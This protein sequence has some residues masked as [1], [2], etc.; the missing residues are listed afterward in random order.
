MRPLLP[1]LSAS[2]LYYTTLLGLARSPAYLS[3]APLL[4]L[5]WP[6]RYLSTVIPAYLYPQLCFLTPF[7]LH[8]LASYCILLRL[9]SNFPFQIPPHV[10][11]PPPTT[12]HFR[13]KYVHTG[14]LFLVPPHPHPASLSSVGSSIRNQMSIFVN[15]N[16]FSCSEGKWVSNRVQPVSLEVRWCDR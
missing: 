9:P 16:S 14:L 11:L 4:F 10:S 5:C 7:H 8:P 3:L 13:D 1:R 12:P 2:S 6:V 15:G